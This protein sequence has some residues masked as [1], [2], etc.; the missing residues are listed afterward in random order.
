[1]VMEDERDTRENETEEREIQERRTLKRFNLRLQAILKELQDREKAVELVTRDISSD[2]AFLVT[3]S[4]LPLDSGVELTL[5]LPAGEVKKSKI[6]VD[7]R[8]VRA[9]SE[10]IAVRFDSRYSFTPV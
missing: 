6:R 8:V 5:F 4:P 3:D 2:G 7:G 10:G 9:E 1:M